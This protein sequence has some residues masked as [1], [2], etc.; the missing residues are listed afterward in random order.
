MDGEKYENFKFKSNKSAGWI[1]PKLLDYKNDYQNNLDYAIFYLK[2]PVNMGL[3]PAKT[4]EDMKPQYVLGNIDRGL[5]LVKRYKEA[6]EGESGSPILNSSCHVM[7]LMI[8]SDGSYTP[9]SAVLDALSR[10][11]LK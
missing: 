5:N 7:G 2:N 9:I 3:I 11:P 6:K 1:T 8:K 10:L 4:G